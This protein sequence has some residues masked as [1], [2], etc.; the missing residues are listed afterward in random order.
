MFEMRKISKVFPGGV[1]ANNEVD[2]SIDEGRIHALL[3]ENGSGKT[4]LMN[5]LYG[6]HKPTGGNIL[7]AGKPVSIDSPSKAIA[8]GIG[9]VHQHFMLVP[10]LTVAENVVLGVRAKRGKLNPFLNLK[11]AEERIHAI[12]VEYGLK[13]DPRTEVWKLAVGVQQRVEVL[14]TLYR[15]VKVLILDE[16]TAVLTPQ[17]VADMIQ[18]LQKLTEHGKS[19]VFISHK[20][21][22]V[23]ALADEITVLRNGK[24]EGQV[25]KSQTSAEALARMMVGRTVEPPKLPLRRPGRVVLKVADAVVEDDRM[26]MAVNGVSFE[27][28][29]GEILG[30]AGVD[31]NGQKELVEAIAGVRPLKS[32]SVEVMGSPVNR[33]QRTRSIGHVTENRHKT[34]VVM[35]FTLWENYSIKTCD[36]PPYKRW[37]GLDISA[38]R[39]ATAQAIREFSIKTQGP[40]EKISSL[41]GGNQQK[42]V[43]AR[44]LGLKAKLLLVAQPTRGL[45]VGAAEYVQNRLIRERQREMAILLVSTELEEILVLSD[46]IIVMYEGSIMGIVKPAETTRET[47]GLM[48]AGS[49]PAD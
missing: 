3:G 15:D 24:R 29:A 31:G 37:S 2:F 34:S 49:V 12:S 22:E 32:G 14:K 28:R 44:E 19:I 13:V 42:V 11:Q 23:M 1:V 35:G 7:Q 4:T 46:R 26:L 47:L 43:L 30:I 41:S 45:D 48:M 8:C 36:M 40:D 25:K 39:S 9:M 6:I 16:P 10:A 38:M 21:N 27:L 20:L 33:H 17:E 5:I 18:V